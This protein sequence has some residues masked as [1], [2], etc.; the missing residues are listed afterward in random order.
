MVALAQHPQ[1]AALLKRCVQLGLNDQETELLRD[2]MGWNN[3]DGS[4]PES[5]DG[6]EPQLSV[7]VMVGIAEPAYIEKAKAISDLLQHLIGDKKMACV[8]AN[9]VRTLQ[10]QLK[11]PLLS[12]VW[13]VAQLGVHE[14]CPEIISEINRLAIE[15]PEKM[16]RA[17]VGPT[18]ARLLG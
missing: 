1:E 7:R 17:V 14:T 3:P 11:L 12:V 10:D 6:I 4:L 18:L 5:F 9:P 13:L 2:I 16:P 15:S 8:R